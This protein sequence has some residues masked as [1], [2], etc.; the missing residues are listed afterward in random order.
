MCC[1]SR[2]RKDAHKGDSEII[3]LPPQFQGW[4]VCCFWFSRLNSS[5][6]ELGGWDPSQLWD[7]DPPPPLVIAAE[8]GPPIGSGKQRVKPKRII[9]KP[10]GLI[11]FTLWDFGITWDLI[12]SSSFQFLLLE[13][14]TLYMSRHYI[15]EAL[16]LSDVIGSKL[17]RN[18][19]S[20][21]IITEFSL[22]SNLVDI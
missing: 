15:L 9:L 8:L 20:G 10:Q 16:N 11:L 6:L 12:P 19:A 7:C 18:F 1:S 3:G 13:K 22:I 2:Q 5:H 17:E 21:W 4:E 14:S